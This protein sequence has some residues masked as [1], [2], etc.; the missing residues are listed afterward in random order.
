MRALHLYDTIIA[1][2][3]L[4]FE[5][6]LKAADRLFALDEKPA[7]A[8]VYRAVAWYALKS[9]HPL[10]AVVAA[11][12]LETMGAPHE[13][14][15]A[16]L[17]A[18]YG[19]D[20]DLIH[21]FAARIALP[22]PD[23][24]CELPSPD[25]PPPALADE[26]EQVATALQVFTRE[27]L[28]RNLMATNP[29][30]RPFNRLQRLD[31]LRRFSQHDVAAGTPLIQEGEDG[32]G[33]FVVLSGEVEVTKRNASGS[34]MP[35]ATLRTGDVFGEMS[36]IEG[37][38]TTATVSAARPSIVLFLGRESVVRMIAGVPEIKDYLEELAAD[39]QVDTALLVSRGE[40]AEVASADERILI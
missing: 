11:R 39:R 22:A 1:T 24:P 19:R 38:P 27:R 7:A 13:D 21:T 14:L 36:L 2:Y 23:S 10:T 29:L 16:G 25:A 12:V 20:S 8:A 18:Y 32:R 31:L 33:L 6:R 4:D 15:L 3:P 9:G 34:V 5:A 35:L 28:L 40:S 17:V 30:F 37:G 26:L